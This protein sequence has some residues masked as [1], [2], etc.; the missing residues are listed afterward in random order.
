MKWLIIFQ[1]EVMV[2]KSKK[3][4]MDMNITDYKMADSFKQFT[5][6]QP[7]ASDDPRTLRE[8]AHGARTIINTPTTLPV[9]AFDQRIINFQAIFNERKT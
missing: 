7:E 5:T 8:L 6:V 4:S 1:W 2:E 3:C 9:V